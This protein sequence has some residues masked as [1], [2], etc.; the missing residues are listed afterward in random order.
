MATTRAQNLAYYDAIPQQ[1]LEVVDGVLRYESGLRDIGKE[2]ARTPGEGISL[3]YETLLDSDDV[4]DEVLYTLLFTN[5][6]KT[7][8]VEKHSQPC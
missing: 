2:S 5:M 3:N 1:S 4:D 8:N 7:F 6:Y